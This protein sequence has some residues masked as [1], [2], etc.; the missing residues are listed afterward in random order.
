MASF[1]KV[2][3]LLCVLGL[4]S[5]PALEARELKAAL[6]TI[7]GCSSYRTLGGGRRACTA[8]TNGW[9]FVAGDGGCVRQSTTV[10]RP[11]LGGVGGVYGRPGGVYGVPGGVYGR[12]SGVYGRPGGVYSQTTV[13]R[14]GGVYGR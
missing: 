10:M 7:E 2:A 3:A 13:A 8:C 9:A 14:P 11:G 12:P 5:A 1:A 4:I 6:Y